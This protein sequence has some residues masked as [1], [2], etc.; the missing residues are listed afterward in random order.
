MPSQPKPSPCR[1]TT[2]M[3]LLNKQQLL[4]IAI[5]H[6]IGRHNNPNNPNPSALLALLSVSS[7]LLQSASK[8]QPVFF[9]L[10]CC[11]PCCSNDIIYPRSPKLRRQRQLRM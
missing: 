6:S 5:A 7:S 10:L 8:Q 1:H 9:L 11:C 2:L 3:L 4:R